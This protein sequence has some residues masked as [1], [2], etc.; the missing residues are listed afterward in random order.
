MEIHLE[1]FNRIL[2]NSRGAVKTFLM[3]Q[4]LIAGLGNIYS[5]EVLFQ[6][7]ILP[8]A[9][10]GRMDENQVRKLYQAMR[11]VLKTTIRHR[12]DP[13]R[14]PRSYLI[15]RR[16]QGA[17]CPRCSRR[18]KRIKINQRSAYFCPACQKQP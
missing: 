11:R 8:Q 5:D 9:R 6:A 10:S 2:K 14:F 4:K 16:K 18:I 15:P 3:N 13:E 17:E 7:G 1:E 12:A